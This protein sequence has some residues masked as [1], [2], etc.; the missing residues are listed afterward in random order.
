MGISE[1]RYPLSRPG[2]RNNHSLP[3][4]PIE[5]ALYMLPVLNRNL[6]QDMQDR[7]NTRVSAD[8]IGP[9]HIAHSIQGVWEGSLQANYVLDHSGRGRG[10][11]L[12]QLYLEGWLWLV[13]MSMG[14]AVFKGWQRL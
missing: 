10:T 11:C 13:V 2:D 1:G 5:C 14:N 3:D 6:L 12:G 9:Q 8:G 4:H 7:G